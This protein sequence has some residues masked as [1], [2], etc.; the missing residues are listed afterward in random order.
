[1]KSL[2]IS[3]FVLGVFLLSL[4]M[5][6]LFKTMR[7][8]DIYT[9]ENT[10]RNRIGDVTIRYPEILDMLER[11]PGESNV[12]FAIRINKVVNDGFMHYWKKEGIDKYHLRVPIW[13]NYMLY[14]ASYINPVRYE[15][16]EFSDYKKNL[17]RGA[18][19]CS[20]HSIV[21]KGI[22]Q[23]NGMRAE[24]M[25]VGGRHVVVRAEL[26]DT[27]TYILDPDYGIVVP[28]DTAEIQA[29]PEL[30]RE[31]YS[32]MHELYYSDAVDP[33]TTDFIV[34]IFGSYKKM[35][36]VDHWFEHFSY[37]AIWIL[38]FLL[39]IPLGISLSRNKQKVKS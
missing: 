27:A 12:D 30:V 4:N 32:K 33:Y 38:P 8:P 25:D 23:E 11:K 3:L 10:L 20:A 7:N 17:E 6:G 9:E 35:Y 34:E 19:L 5:I 21:V 28:Y 2:K 18:G 13:E 15:R 36:D 39:M 26:N 29:N 31:P 16:Y 1:M 24:L 22:L 37:K 14:F